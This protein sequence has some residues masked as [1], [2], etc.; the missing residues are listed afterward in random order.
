[1]IR[2]GAHGRDAYHCASSKLRAFGKSVFGV[3][4]F[5]RKAMAGSRPA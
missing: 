4:G 5:C 1:M 3:S 2:H